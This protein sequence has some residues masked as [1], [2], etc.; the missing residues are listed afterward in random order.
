MTAGDWI[1]YVLVV[2]LV[3]VVAVFVV[4]IVAKH[5][6]DRDREHESGWL[7]DH[8]D[9]ERKDPPYKRGTKRGGR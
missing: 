1:G 2:A 8:V 3:L 7:H 6:V 9:R 5:V 4:P